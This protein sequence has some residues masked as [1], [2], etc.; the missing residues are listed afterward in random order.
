MSEGSLDPA[1]HIDTPIPDAASPSFEDAMHRF[2]EA[3]HATAEAFRATGRAVG[4]SASSFVSGLGVALPEARDQV[5]GSIQVRPLTAILMSAA[6]GL[7][8][9]VTLARR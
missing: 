9:G 5:A 7:L 4:R 6:V 2:G 8:A 3:A 1:T